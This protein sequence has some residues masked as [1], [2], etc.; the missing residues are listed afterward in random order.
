MDQF[1]QIL[2]ELAGIRKLILGNQTDYCETE[3][4]CIII[5]VNNPRYLAQ[6]FRRNLLPRY[7][8]ADGYKY[9]KSDCRKIASSLDSKTIVLEPLTK[10]K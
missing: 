5:G 10:S 2:K 8:R 1:E 3:E 7:E 4:A 9:K 6:L